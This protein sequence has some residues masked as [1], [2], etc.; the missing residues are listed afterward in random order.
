[1][2]GGAR[3]DSAGL[4]VGHAAATGLHCLAW[5]RVGAVGARTRPAGCK[6]RG[7]RSP[8]LYAGLE[9]RQTT[10]RQQMLLFW[11]SH[12]HQRRRHL[13]GHGAERMECMPTNACLQEL[14][15][16]EMAQKASAQL[17]DRRAHIQVW[18]GLLA[19]NRHTLKQR[20]RL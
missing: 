5:A 16:P 6:M 2:P 10:L 11:A 3:R 9:A 8:R 7:W 12:R 17:A 20:A 18:C 15:A 14:T 13:S 19:A 4:Q 1:M